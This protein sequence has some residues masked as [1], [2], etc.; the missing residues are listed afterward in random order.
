M[1]IRREKERD[2]FV[3]HMEIFRKKG[4]ADPKFLIKTAFYQK[5]KFGR[6]VQFFDSELNK[7]E[8]LYLE[9]YENVKNETGDIIDIVPLYPERHLFKYKYNPFFEEEYEQ[10]ENTNRNGDSYMVY[11]VPVNE[12]L[13]V[14][15]DGSEVTF[16]E[17]ERME[18]ELKQKSNEIPKLQNNLAFPDFEEEF[19]PKQEVTSPSLE[20][21][22]APL[23]EITIRDL[24]AIMLIK[25]ISGR[26]WLN[27]LIKKSKS[28]L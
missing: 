14:L 6:Q 16:K 10:K 22:D 28:E 18:A 27:E 25:P 11:T 21:E 1:T 9:F 15:K 13:V 3:Q 24:V 12:M 17:F 8:D 5:G 19:A 26:N 20:I 7:G 23:S 4:I 2:F